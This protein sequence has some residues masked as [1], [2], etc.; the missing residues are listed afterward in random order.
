MYRGLADRGEPLASRSIP[1][2]APADGKQHCCG[3]SRNNGD[4]CAARA[5][6]RGRPVQAMCG[7]PLA[8]PLAI[9]SQ[10]GPRWNEATAGG[11]LLREY[12]FCQPSFRPIAR[13]RMPEP[14]KAKHLLGVQVSVGTAAADRVWRRHVFGILGKLSAH[15][16]SAR[17]KTS[18]DL[19]PIQ[20][21]LVS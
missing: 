12:R 10:R 5:P 9:R 4:R 7:N 2:R 13:Q 15:G 17:A 21:K 11:Q 19:R 8:G 16:S 14:R 1:I 18:R 20:P 3:R 6:R